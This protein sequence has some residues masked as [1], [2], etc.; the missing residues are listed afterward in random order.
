MP[1]TLIVKNIE[2][3]TFLMYGHKMKMKSSNTG[4]IFAIFSA[5]LFGAST[6]ASKYFLS[7]VN[8]ILLSGL[9]YF[10]SGVILFLILM[11]RKLISGHNN[12]HLKL[13]N[14]DK[15]KLILST[16]FGGVAGPVLLMFGL[17]KI[18][19]SSASLLLNFESVFTAIISWII[20]REHT[21]RNLI[22][23]MLL[24]FL[25][26]CVL[27]FNNQFHISNIVGIVYI[28]LACISWGFDN[29]ITREISENDPFII[30]AFKSTFAGLTNLFIS[31]IIGYTGSI[32]LHQS[33]QITI[34]GFLGYG[35]SII[36]FI[37]SL[38]HIGTARTSAY[39]SISP[40]LGSLIA[41]I[42]LKEPTSIQLLIAAILMGAGVWLHLTEEH[43]HEHSHEECEHS[44][45]HVH[46]EHHQH[47]HTENDPK[48]EPHTHWHKHE[49]LI[50][51][52]PHYP[53]T[54]HRHKH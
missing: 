13:N 42:F 14:K 32:S 4:Y 2:K 43:D 41:I 28:I 34:V 26:G 24:I 35:L 11:I 18:S 5:L 31:F 8:P 27:S 16:L 46:D 22:F 33:I 6:P 3:Y 50:H 45:K 20:F 39:F 1:S 52:H 40:F 53:D 47:A 23:G 44:H 54:Y 30:V 19:A 48:G 29:N 17:Q 10:G 37:I 49:P 15:I 12:T 25:G 38:R 36:L 51:S 21:N 7:Y 9:L